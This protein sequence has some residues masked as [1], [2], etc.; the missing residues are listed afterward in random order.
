[1]L[2]FKVLPPHP[3]DLSEDKGEVALTN[4]DEAHLSDQSDELQTITNPA[5]VPAVHSD[6]HFA[7]SL[8]THALSKPQAEEKLNSCGLKQGDVTR[9][10]PV[11]QD[12]V[13]RASLSKQ[14]TEGRLMSLINQNNRY[15][16]SIPEHEKLFSERETDKTAISKEQVTIESSASKEKVKSGYPEQKSFIELSSLEQNAAESF[17]VNHEDLNEP[18]GTSLENQAISSFPQQKIFTKQFTPEDGYQVQS[19][20]PKEEE[21]VYDSSQCYVKLQVR[22][23][24]IL[25]SQ[26]VE[27]FAQVGSLCGE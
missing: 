19:S 12:E 26:P 11:P 4:S 23:A 22:R 1:M 17:P 8:S 10:P 21:T 7:N 18:F 3:V 14:D 24:R 2:L 13:L 5:D 15:E 9:P 6:L 27:D 25:T 16:S 20:T